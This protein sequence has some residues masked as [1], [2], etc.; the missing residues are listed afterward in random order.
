MADDTP[1]QAMKR[2]MA[3]VLEPQPKT[4]KVAFLS[5]SLLVLEIP[6][7]TNTSLPV[8]E[9]LT[10]Q[11][12]DIAWTVSPYSISVQLTPTTTKLRKSKT[13][14][15]SASGGVQNSPASSGVPRPQMV[16][17]SIPQQH[18]SSSQD[19]SCVVLTFSPDTTQLLPCP[20]CLPQTMTP[21]TS[22]TVCL[23][24]LITQ[25]QT[26]RQPG[27]IT[28]NPALP[29]SQTPTTTPTRPQTRSRAPAAFSFHTRGPEVQIC[30]NFL[31]S[32]CCSGTTERNLHHT[33]FPFRWQLWCTT[34]YQWVDISP[35]SQILLEK[36]YCDVEQD[37]VCIKD[38]DLRYELN[39]DSMEL[40]GS[41]KYNG[42]RRLSNSDS[43]E[44]NHYF[45]SEWKIY[46]WG[47]LTWEEYNKVKVILFR[48]LRLFS[49]SLFFEK[50]PECSFHINSL[51]YKEVRCRP[52]IALVNISTS[53][54]LSSTLTLRTGLQTDST[55][56]AGDPPEANFSIDPLEEF[57][58]WYPPVWR[59]ASKEDYSLI[60][61]PAG[62]KTYWKVQSVFY[63][64]MSETRVDIV[65]IQQL[66]NLLHWDKYQRSSCFSKEPLERHLFHGTSKEASEDICH[67][68]FDPRL[69]GINGVSF[70][71]GTYF[72]TTAAYS[73]TFSVRM[74]SAQLH[75]MFLAKVLVGKKSV[76]RH[77]Y[78]RPPP[79]DPMT[80]QYR[81]YDSCVDS[82][83]KPSIFVVFDSCQCYPYYLIKYKDIP[84]EID[85]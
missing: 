66:Q 12:V 45:P 17:Q 15:K 6:A 42:V 14:S 75:H 30:D 29:T 53:S 25:P 11:Q 48:L 67:N 72:A 70:G 51:E 63:E 32:S 81:L 79:L 4:S 77:K 83:D 39:F 18:N 65:S 52:L 64:S 71:F 56:R 20:P 13:S 55:E 27:T 59:L 26:A 76:G 61:V 21:A 58:S 31:L 43:L 35:R 62:T 19:A 23:P 38:G 33:P 24:L 69:A 73:N 82:I 16:V 2:K 47:D 68:N 50:E 8:W 54:L 74:S 60:D 49:F 7:D 3:S 22:L 57:T 78:R 10:S 1:S 85:I 9:A 36:I 40:D 34:T 46:W 41:L 37:K 80:K 84:K 28:K 5:P 44:R